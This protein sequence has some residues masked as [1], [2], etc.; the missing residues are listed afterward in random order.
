MRSC[1]CTVADEHSS[2]PY[3]ILLNTFLWKTRELPELL[4]SIPLDGEQSTQSK[5][6]DLQLVTMNLSKTTFAREC[7][8][9]Q[10]ILEMYQNPGAGAVSRIDTWTLTSG[11][12][13]EPFGSRKVCTRFDEQLEWIHSHYTRNPIISPSPFWNSIISPSW[14]YRSEFRGWYNR[15]PM[16][17][18]GNSIISLFLH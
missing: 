14:F 11:V 5:S 12:T 7:A 13:R 3:R 4:H 6:C 10:N 17:V 16:E 15:V 8:N 2:E 1:V 9:Q 18:Y